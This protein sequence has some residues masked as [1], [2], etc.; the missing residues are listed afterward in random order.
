[1]KSNNYQVTSF[2]EA[3]AF[4]SNRITGGKDQNNALKET[5]TFLKLKI[6]H[7]RKTKEKTYERALI[8]LL[9]CNSTIDTGLKIVYEVNYKDKLDQH[10]EK[11]I[12]VNNF[13]NVDLRKQ[14]KRAIAYKNTEYIQNIYQ[15]YRFKCE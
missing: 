13:R 11:R 1:M 12:V 2:L 9:Q 14:D 6:I 4:T 3:L 5:P 15:L 10:Q 8:E 7:N